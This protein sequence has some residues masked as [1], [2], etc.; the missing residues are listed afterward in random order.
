MGKKKTAMK[1]SFD[2]HIQ[3]TAIKSQ[4]NTT[5]PLNDISSWLCAR[6]VLL[7]LNLAGTHRGKIM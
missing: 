6:N 7:K 2:L 5:L 1:G 4:H 3:N